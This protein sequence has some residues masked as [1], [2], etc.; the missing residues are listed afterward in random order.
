[1]K[2]TPSDKEAKVVV[3]LDDNENVVE[4]VV[5]EEADICEVV[6]F[7]WLIIN[8]D[9]MRPDL[10]THLAGHVALLNT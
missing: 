5:M 2:D 3:V 9:S 7:E 8:F 1:M 6:D 4:E 10:E